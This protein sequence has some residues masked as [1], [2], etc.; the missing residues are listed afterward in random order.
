MGRRKGNGANGIVAL[1]IGAVV[2][3][4]LIPKQVWIALFWLMALAVA[5]WIGWRMYRSWQSTHQASALPPP[6]PEDT[7]KTLAQILGESIGTGAPQC[8]Q[9][10]INAS[11]A[12]ANGD[13]LSATAT[14]TAYRGMAT[15]TPAPAQE[16]VAVRTTSPLRAAADWA[17]PIRQPTSPRWIPFGESISV[18]GQSIAG[19][20]FYLG[21]PRSFQD[22]RLPAIDPTLP[23]SGH[24]DWRG[25]GLGY[26]PRYAGLNDRE[27]GTLLAFLNSE[28]RAPTV[29]IGYV[30]LYFYGL[31]HRLL[32]G[33][34]NTADGRGEGQE[35]LDE[36]V[37]LQQYYGGH[38]SFRR[39][40]QEL[41]AVGRFK[42]GLSDGDVPS[43]D[44]WTLSQHIQIAQTVAR[45]QPLTVDLAFAWAHALTDEARSS[46]WDVVRPEIKARFSQLYTERFAGGLVIKPGRSKLALS[47]RWAGPGEGTETIQT[48]LPD[49]TR[50]QAPIR[51]LVT[52]MQQAMGELEALRRVRR[53]KNGT[54][55]AELAAMPDALRGGQ[56]PA[57]FRALVSELNGLLEQQSAASIATSRLIGGCGMSLPERLGKREA[58]SLI[59]ALEALGFAIEPDVRFHGQLPA[60]DGQV[61]VF[62]LP[63]HAARTPT[64]AYAAALLMLQA[65]LVVAGQDSQIS[66]S[67]L[68]VAVAAIERQFALPDSERRRIEAHLRWLQ[69]NPVTIARLE[70]RVRLLATPER[71]AFAGVLL[72]IAA[73]DGHVTPAEVRVIERFYRALELDPARVPADLHHVS[74]GGRP[75]AGT[76]A[77]LDA[78]VIAEKLAETVRVQSVLAQIFSDAETPEVAATAPGIVPATPP[79]SLSPSSPENGSLEVPGLDAEHMELLQ[80]IL[81]APDGQWSRSD[82][83]AACDTLGLLPDG[84]AE[85]LNE[86]AFSITGEAL[87]EGD[88]PVYVNDYV[89]DQLTQTST[90]Q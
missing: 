49:I 36:V 12:P 72:E 5:C 38:N 82:F 19:G 54:P 32:R 11:S 37:R 68:D 18:R 70:S 44:D 78:D 88:D 6:P 13:Q 90:E 8:R 64:S 27:R 17:G 1:L 31:E 47:Y 35:I 58:T 61:V 46:T 39:Y 24:A 28:R 56:A 7:G 14:R 53:S 22:S 52:L 73:A 3:I 10:G 89:R 71:E 45:G 69:L 77:T 48:D 76:G 65:A 60:L 51:P 25:E 29:G 57:T 34:D 26:W 84:A 66:Q 83:E 15:I 20:G 63:E 4:A 42:L 9:E 75:K 33:L 59:Q 74:V 79:A 2:L 80:R 81:E 85:M 87:L 23:F 21:T 16:P 62:R 41:L 30:F 55:L 43:V 50:S 67:E 86:A 40:S